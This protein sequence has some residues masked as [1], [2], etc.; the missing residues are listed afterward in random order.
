MKM[1]RR[2][3]FIILILTAAI[4]L[5][6]PGVSAVSQD[7]LI[8]E[9][10]ASAG[11]QSVSEAI[12]RE[13]TNSL[14]KLGIDPEHPTAGMRG[15]SLSDLVGILKSELLGVVSAPLRS[16]AAIL[17]VI[18]LT[19]M[20]S[21]EKHRILRA[22][23]VAGAGIAIIAPVGALAVSA[24]ETVSVCSVFTSASI[25]VFGALT[26]SGGFPVSSAFMSGYMVA[27]SEVLSLLAS[28]VLVPIA[29]I[30]L[31]FSAVGAFVP[32]IKT[33]K[34]ASA[35]RSFAIWGV[36]G[37]LALYLTFIGIQ[38]GITSSLDGLAKKTVNVTVSSVIPVVGKIISDASDT[39]LGAAELIKSGFGGFSLVVILLIFAKPLLSAVAWAAA[40]RIADF[41]AASFGEDGISSL[42]G[43]A[44]KTVTVLIAVLASV[45]VALTVSVAVIVRL[46]G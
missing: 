27:L 8:A 23:S 30:A 3:A 29:C 6:A 17:A 15:F 34:T 40:L 9:Q 26:V 16:L 4:T 1:K 24:A 14:D 25:P 37:A 18:F 11:I 10:E 35:I 45:A 38:S 5:L 44:Q 36:G 42:T 39:V 7:E 13:V 20:L 12:P 33:E 31:A 21:D 28:S 41:A 43:A 32:E 2:I 19:S 46:K 22:V